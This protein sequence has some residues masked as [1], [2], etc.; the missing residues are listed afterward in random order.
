[1]THRA[2]A[3]VDGIVLRR[4]NVVPAGVVNVAG[5]T[6]RSVRVP[7]AGIGDVVRVRAVVSVGV[8][9]AAA[10]GVGAV[11]GGL[12]WVRVREGEA[13]SEEGGERSKK[14]K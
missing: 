1:M 6:V 13:A 2:G 11:E 8:P 9:R 12:G 10:V 14:A 4:L 5:R 7:G 3:G